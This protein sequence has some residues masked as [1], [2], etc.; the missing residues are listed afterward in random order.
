MTQRRWDDYLV[1]EKRQVYIRILM[2][3]FFAVTLPLIGL[4]HLDVGGER[5]PMDGIVA[6]AFVI[7]IFYFFYILKFPYRHQRFRIFVM[8]LIDLL[9][10]IF[11]FSFAGEVGAYFAGILLW[12]VV[13]YSM[14]YDKTVAYTVYV[15][16]L[17]AWGL[18]FFLSPYWNTHPAIYIGWL[19]TYVV[20]P[21][22]FFK[23]LSQIRQHIDRLYE[24]VAVNSFKATHDP[25]TELPNR[26]CITETIQKRID[27]K[28]P[29][30]LLFI[31]LDGF[32][33]VN[34]QFGHDVGDDVLIDV[35]KRLLEKD[36]YVAR[37]GGDEFAA[38]VDS[39]DP[40]KIGE[41]AQDII[42]SIEKSY[43]GNEVKISCSIGIALFP[44]DADTEFLLKKRA[45]EAMY[46]AKFSG[47]GR[48]W[49]YS[50]VNEELK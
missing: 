44:H 7:N 21:L 36:I 25:L 50:K 46:K 4:D 3:L 26:F 42:D 31:D 38:I 13:G 40:E 18:L 39:S 16:V 6:L 43:A 32:K 17:I 35:S 34:D 2:Y 8:A 20:I 9:F 47:K 33:R 23:L 1:N 45:D 22:Y 27:A 15:F 30:A 14:R 48:Y 29:F 28:M 12:Y 49:F 11:A 41:V 24:D 37:M 5:I 19:I 10:T